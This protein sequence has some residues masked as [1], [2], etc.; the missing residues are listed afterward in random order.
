MH[1]IDITSNGDFPIVFNE[2][3]KLYFSVTRWGVSTVIILENVD[4]ATTTFGMDAG[5]GTFLAFPSGTISDGDVIN[6]GDGVELMV[7]VSGITS[8][9]VKI[10]LIPHNKV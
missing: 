9:P 4:G 5:E 8:N 1:I 3:S 2:G 7:R 6:H 10:G